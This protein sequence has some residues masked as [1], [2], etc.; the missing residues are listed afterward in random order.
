MKMIDSKSKDF[1]MLLPIGDIKRMVDEMFNQI[2]EQT[3]NADFDMK[4]KE[5]MDAFNKT[6]EEM[7]NIDD[8][9]INKLKAQLMGMGSEHP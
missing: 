6:F 5:V 2:I 3:S 7:G 4:R 8:E 1:G 9:E